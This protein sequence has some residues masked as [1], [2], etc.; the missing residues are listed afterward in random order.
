MARFESREELIGTIEWEGGIDEAIAYGIKPD[1]M[2]PDVDGEVDEHLQRLW[3]Y[4]VSAH[5][6]FEDVAEQIR[7][8]LGL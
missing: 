1:D 7:E 8:E 5:E 3:K 4:A 6:R 2:P